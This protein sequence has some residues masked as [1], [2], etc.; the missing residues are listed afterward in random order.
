[1]RLRE[2]PGGAEGVVVGV[3]VLADRSRRSGCQSPTFFPRHC[4][5]AAFVLRRRSRTV[6]GVGDVDYHK[7]FFFSV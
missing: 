4:V 2:H 3:P 7:S 6:E 1:M 5:G